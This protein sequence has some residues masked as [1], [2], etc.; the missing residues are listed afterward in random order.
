MSDKEF[1]KRNLILPIYLPSLL[2]E[3]ALS[4]LF[5]VLPV[6]ATEYGFDLASAGAVITAAMLGTLLFEAPA[7]LIVNRIGERASMLLASVV[8]AGFGVLGFLNLGY[9]AL[10]IAAVGFGA[11]F[12]LFGLSRHSLLADLV[13]QDHRAKSMSLLGGSFRGGAALGPVLGSVFIANFG[14]ES[15]YLVAAALCLLGGVSVLAVPA[16]KLSSSPSGQNGNIWEVAVRERSKLLTLGVASMIISAGRTIRMIGLPLLAIQLGIDA[17]TSSFIFGFTGLIDFALFYA[18]GLI[19]DRWGKFWSSV[20]TLIALGVSYLFAFLVTDLTSFWV[21]AS[22]TALANAAS[23]GINM[24]LGADMA[25][26]GSRSEFLA[27]F[28]MLTSGGVVAAPAAISGITALLGLPAA[29]AIT[30]LINFYGA[31]LFWRYLPLH[32]PDKHLGD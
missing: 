19:M 31:F 12:S 5:P 30:G 28:R 20:P 25:P 8:A 6:S 14:I 23:A 21:L 16:K 11:M 15:A 24:V 26:E 10:L 18:S 7:S 27:A 17:A 3:A 13:P 9:V 4:A 32:A 2:F 29:L 22:A 1:R